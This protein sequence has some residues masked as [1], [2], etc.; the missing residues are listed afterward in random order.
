MYN[1]LGHFNGGVCMEKWDVY[2][3][4]GNLTGYTK[5]RED[6]WTSEEYHLGASLWIINN[7]R[8]LLIQ[9]RSASKKRC[10]NVWC[11]IGGSVIASESSRQG[12]VREVNEEVGIK[13]NEENLIFL[14]RIIF[15]NTLCDEYV[16]IDDFPIEK[17]VM[18]PEEVSE[19]KWA[20]MEEIKSLFAQK[21]FMVDT[22]EDIEKLEKYINKNIRL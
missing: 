3:K 1:Y 8:E 13:V 20:S 15:P 2:D 9:K 5:T 11:N 12:C 4:Y 14:Q 22:L 18:Q 17:V 6:I 7:K 19:V 21:I 10:P 16:L